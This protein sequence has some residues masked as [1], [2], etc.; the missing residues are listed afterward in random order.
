MKFYIAMREGG[1]KEV[2][3]KKVVIPGFEDFE[4]FQHKSENGPGYAISETTT[5]RLV[6]S[7]GTLKEAKQ[8]A[9]K[10]LQAHAQ[11]LEKIIEDARVSGSGN[12]SPLYKPEPEKEEKEKE[13]VVMNKPEEKEKKKVTKDKPKE[14][15]VVKN[16][17]YQIV[18]ENLLKALENDNLKW[19]PMRKI[20]GINMPYNAVSKRAY[21]GINR[22]STYLTA[23]MFGDWRFLTYKQIK[24]KGGGLKKDAKGTPILFYKKKDICYRC[25]N[26][27]NCSEE[28]KKQVC[29]DYRNNEEKEENEI[30]PNFMEDLRVY[31]L[32]SRFYTI[33]NVQQTS[34]EDDD[35]EIIEAA[36]SE[37]TDD[38]TN[39]RAFLLNTGAVFK[40]GM[41]PYYNLTN[42]TIFV[43]DRRKYD[44]IGIFYH[45]IFHELA[46]WTGREDR[47][48]RPS[49]KTLEEDRKE[50]DTYA[51]EEL[52][53]EISSLFLCMKFNIVDEKIF[54]NSV[55]Y[56][57]SWLKKLRDDPSLIVRASTQAEKVVSYL[58]GLQKAQVA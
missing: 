24:N 40:K 48:S 12:V 42:D 5:G 20:E 4:F 38:F 31:P 58:E 10:Q 34:L 21:T 29:Q 3:G 8:I 13:E 36:E 55:A 1:F 49:F 43:P 47:L 16:K 25:V 11:N 26:E 15:E 51:F 57:K 9:I 17:V 50:E 22:L 14:E 32:M 35:V 45:D 33:Y 23:L 18:V 41:K 37:A 7:A 28:T 30:C 56:L 6:A 46:H 19:Q 53:A 54:S 39:I 27:D 2:E 52:I 44:N